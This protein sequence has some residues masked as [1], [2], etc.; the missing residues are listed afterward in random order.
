MALF[1]ILGLSVAGFAGVLSLRTATLVVVP[2]ASLPSVALV[3]V[4]YWLTVRSARATTVARD[5]QRAP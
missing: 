1:G 5:P 4:G 2:M 3:A